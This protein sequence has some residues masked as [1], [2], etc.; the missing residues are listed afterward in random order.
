MTRGAQCLIPKHD[1]EDVRPCNPFNIFNAVVLKQKYTPKKHVTQKVQPP[2]FFFLFFSPHLYFPSFWT[3]RGHTGVA[4][5]PPRYFPSVF[6]AHKSSAIPMLLVYY[7][8]SVVAKVTHA[9]ALSASQ[10]V[11][12]KKKVRKNSYE[13]ALGGTRTP[14]TDLYQGRVLRQR[15]TTF[16][17]GVPQCESLRPPRKT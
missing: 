1:Y 4:R 15:C 16:F 13:Y 8:S 2:R 5:S 9:L 10:F 6:I 12:K 3:S 14:E 11:H 7:S 17:S